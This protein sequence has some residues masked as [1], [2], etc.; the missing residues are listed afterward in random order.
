MSDKILS[1]REALRVIGTAAATVVGMNIFKGDTPR[2]PEIELNSRVLVLDFFD[3]PKPSRENLLDT[4]PQTDDEIKSLV[5]D[6]YKQNFGN[7]GEGVVGVM[8]K[9]AEQIGDKNYKEPNKISILPAVSVGE[10]KK[11]ELGNITVIA[12][13]SEAEV[14]KVVSQTDSSL[15]NLSFEVG[16][17]DVHIDLTKRRV[18]GANYTRDDDPQ[19]GKVN[20]VPWYKDNKGN[21]ISKEKYDELMNEGLTFVTEIGDVYHTD[22]YAGEHTYDNLKSLTN[23][24]RNHP[25]KFFIAAGGNPSDNIPPIVPDI[26]EARKKLEKEGLWPK[27][28]ITTGFT[29]T[30]GDGEVSPMTVGHDI[31][32]SQEDMNNVGLESK[33]SFTTARITE[34]SR[35]L[36]EKGANTHSKLKAS[37]FGMCE[38][39][40]MDKPFDTEVDEISVRVLN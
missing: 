25:D 27:N 26:R 19:S 3:V 35:V 36:I 10:I 20:G 9:T 5:E 1:R 2:S 7:H 8:Q 21:D 18:E 6:Y 13:I 37:L 38:T 11:D 23:I 40:I 16:K 34:I 14:E 31:Y 12:E 30:F 24:A 4:I 33:T 15:V 29:H 39:K 32:L 28:L 22:G 17:F